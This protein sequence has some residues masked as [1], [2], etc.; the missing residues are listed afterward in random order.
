MT[1]NFTAANVAAATAKIAGALRNIRTAMAQRRIRRRADYSIVVQTYP[2]P[3]PTGPGIRYSESGY[4]RQST[5]G[6]GFWNTDAEL[7]QH[8]RAADDQQ[9]GAERGAA[10][11]A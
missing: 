4:T 8:H 11:P 2:S 5:G 3:L 10:S 9:R 7:G 1:A 6:C